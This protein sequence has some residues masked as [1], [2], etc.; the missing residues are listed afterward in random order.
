MYQ[1]M[2]SCV[3]ALTLAL[4]GSTPNL[5]PT[6]LDR[7]ENGVVVLVDIEGH[8]LCAGSIINKV[9]EVLTAAHCVSNLENHFQVQLRNSTQWFSAVVEAADFKTD[10]A[11]VRIIL[12]PENLVV[13]KLAYSSPSI[14]EPVWIIGHPMGYL[15]LVTSGIV[16][17][18]TRQKIMS[19]GYLVEILKTDATINPGNSGGG[20]LNRSGQL[21]G[22]VSSMD[23]LVLN[24]ICATKT[25][26]GNVISLRDIRAFLQE[27]PFYVPNR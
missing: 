23:M 10:L 3:L 4:T 2:L 7:V 16:S 17:G 19:K 25:G 12:P 20:V 5:L 26:I 14:G 6:S 9:G 11:L 18:Y 22:V 27:I 15:H 21:V 8:S 13:T 24:P 1:W